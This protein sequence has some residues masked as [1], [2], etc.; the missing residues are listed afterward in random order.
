VSARD[1]AALRRR[2]TI[3]VLASEILRDAARALGAVGIPVMPLK[4]VLLQ[5]VLYADPAERLMSDV[6]VLV[7][8]HQFG[9]A[10]TALLGAGFR[11]QKVGRSLIEVA[12]SSPKGLAIDLHRRLF[13]LGRYRLTTE[14]V[15]RRAAPDESLFG[16]PLHIAHPH[17]TAAHLIGKLVSDHA[18]SDAVPRLE[19]LA[20]WAAHAQIDP[21]ELAQHLAR[22]VLGRAARYTSAMGTELIGGPFF[23]A[24]LRALPADPVGQACARLARSV[25]PRLDGTALAPVAAHLLNESLARGG[26]SALLALRNRWRHTRL[27]LHGDRS[28]SDWAAVLGSAGF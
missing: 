2:F 23:P 8:E 11:P 6:D 9:Q 24:L 22:S 3:A 27:G 28:P 26:A 10:I 5:R 25:L 17:D 1:A 7:P 15:F 12:L 4:G 18:V 14:A 21:A 16:V 13:S 20:R 19:E